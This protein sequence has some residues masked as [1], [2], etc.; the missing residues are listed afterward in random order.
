MLL[1]IMIGDLIGELTIGS[2]NDQFSLV[3]IGYP[4]E[5]KILGC[6][7]SSGSIVAFLDQMK[8]IY[9]FWRNLKKM[10]I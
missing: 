5:N 1:P 9:C 7:F 3:L 4:A 2:L 10:F 6:A 8:M